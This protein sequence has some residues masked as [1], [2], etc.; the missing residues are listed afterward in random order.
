MVST[1]INRAN[2]SRAQI[3]ARLAQLAPAPANDMGIYALDS[4]YDRHEVLSRL[5]GE[6][7]SSIAASAT[8]DAADCSRSGKLRLAWSIPAWIAGILVLFFSQTPVAGIVALVL[9]TLGLVSGVKK[10]G[11]SNRDR[12]LMNDLRQLFPDPDVGQQDA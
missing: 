2:P 1:V 9:G 4:S 6:D 11:R 7:L 8:M 3:Q 12:I 10:L 5:P